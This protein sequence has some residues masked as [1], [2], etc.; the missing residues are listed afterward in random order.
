MTAPARIVLRP[1]TDEHA[2]RLDRVVARLVRR[3][4]E[5]PRAGDC[6]VWIGATTSEGY[7]FTKE[8]NGARRLVHRTIVEYLLGQDLP[9]C[10]NR[11]WPQRAHL[12]WPHL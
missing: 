5:D 7:G 8:P 1:P 6:F 12:I 2:A 3:P 11:D 9:G 4:H 10:V